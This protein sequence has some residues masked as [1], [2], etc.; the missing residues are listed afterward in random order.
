LPLTLGGDL[1]NAAPHSAEPSISD[2]DEVPVLAG[3]LPAAITYTI[4]RS[5]FSHNRWVL[6]G[7]LTKLIN[8]I[9]QAS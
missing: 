5:C 7:L 9:T 2:E 1:G 6:S 8:S 4:C 3:F